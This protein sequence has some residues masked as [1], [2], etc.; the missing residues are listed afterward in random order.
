MNSSVCKYRQKYLYGIE[1]Y[2]T[3]MCGVTALKVFWLLYFDTAYYD[4]LLC[5]IDTNGALNF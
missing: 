3:H 2:D 4:I 1:L 5:N